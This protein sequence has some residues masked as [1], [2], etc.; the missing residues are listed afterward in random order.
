MEIKSFKPKPAK[1]S[2]GD[3]S[4]RTLRRRVV[5][6]PAHVI[7]NNHKFPCQIR[8]LSL[9]GAKIKLDLPLKDGAKL[10]LEVPSKGISFRC[11]VVWQAEDTIGLIFLESKRQ[12]RET[13]GGQADILGLADDI[14]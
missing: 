14:A 12:V 5:L 3:S 11:E 13:F 9:G 1:K 7:V 6:W 2:A 8:N 4:A 10:N